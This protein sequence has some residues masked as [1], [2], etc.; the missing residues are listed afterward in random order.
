MYFLLLFL[1]TQDEK[2]A[3]ITDEE[4]A[5]VRTHVDEA[6]ASVMSLCDESAKLADHVDPLIT[7]ADIN[8]RA[9]QVATLCRPIMNRPKPI[10]KKTEEPANTGESASTEGTK[11]EEQATAASAD[12][13]AAEPDAMEVEEP[14]KDGEEPSKVDASS[15][16]ETAK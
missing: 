10:P 13:K 9:T 11:E 14:T 12:A 15:G 7:R 2:Y 4:R 8:A 1:S 3:H 6:I 16:S 5:R